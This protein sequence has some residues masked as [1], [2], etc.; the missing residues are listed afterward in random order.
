MGQNHQA[1]GLSAPSLYL[2]S[3]L[4]RGERGICRPEPQVVSPSRIQSRPCSPVPRAPRDGAT[5]FP[6]RPPT[7]PRN[8][9]A[10]CLPGTAWLRPLWA[11][12]FHRPGPARRAG[13][14]SW[15]SPGAQAL[16]GGFQAWLPSAEGL[17]M[18]LRREGRGSQGGPCAWACACTCVT[19]VSLL[20][21]GTHL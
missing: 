8:R 4:L 1:R 2:P 14:P 21:P 20:K 10:F 11:A 15:G 18:V 19:R 9:G 12:A 7:G 6:A 3:L 5:A 17:R 13:L 16:P